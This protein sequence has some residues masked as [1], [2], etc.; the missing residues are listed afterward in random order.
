MIMKKINTHLTSPLITQ[1]LM[2]VQH[3]IKTYGICTL[4]YLWLH[5]EE[6]SYL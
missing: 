6:R 2:L 5:L 3:L 4:L 1:Q